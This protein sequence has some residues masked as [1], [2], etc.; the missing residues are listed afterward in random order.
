[1]TFCQNLIIL[2]RMMKVQEFTKRVGI[3]LEDLAKKLG[4]KPS[5]VYAWSAGKRTPTY[6][7]CVKLMECGM[8]VE[9][10]FGK[11]YLS[12][13]AET[14]QAFEDRIESVMKRMFAKIGKI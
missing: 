13:V 2:L 12:S 5:A 1:M 6:D 3:N 14:H 8:T 4:V 11:P 7:M 10:L 9:E